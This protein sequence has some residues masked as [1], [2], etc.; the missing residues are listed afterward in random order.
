MLRIVGGKVACGIDREDMVH[1]FEAINS[2]IEM[3]QRGG[4]GRTY[5][6]VGYRGSW[7]GDNV[8]QP[9]P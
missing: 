7:S 3:L 5:V 8:M 4:Q 9:R 1:E 6:T 2:L